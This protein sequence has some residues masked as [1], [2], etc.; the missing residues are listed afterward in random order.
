MFFAR[1]LLGITV[2]IGVAWL[3]S[4]DR[5]RFPLKIVLSGMGLQWLL[6]WIVLKTAAG[7]VDMNPRNRPLAGL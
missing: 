3:L 5:R 6:A 7:R 1:G 2:L 4:S